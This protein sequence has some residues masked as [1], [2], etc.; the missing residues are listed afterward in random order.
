MEELNKTRKKIDELNEK[1]ALLLDERISLVKEIGNIKNK[2]KIPIIDK[3][4]EN[5][6]IEKL[7]KLNYKYAQFQDIEKVFEKIL[8]ISR[9]IQDCSY[10]ITFLGPR[11]TFSEQAAQTYFS[12]K[13]NYIPLKSISD[14]FRSVRVGE[15]D[16]GVVPIENSTTGSIGL[17]L[18][19]LL[20]SDIVVSGEIIEKITLCLVAPENLELKDINQIYSHPQP[21]SQ[22]RKYLEENLS[23]AELITTKSTANAAETVSKLKNAAAISSELAGKIYNLKIIRKGIE[24]APN[25]YTRFFVIGKFQVPETGK[26]KTSIAFS[27][28]HV[29]G[30]LVKALKVFAERNINLTKLESRPSK[31]TPW[32][33]FFYTDFEGHRDN[34]LCEEALQELKSYTNMIKIFGS[35][36][37]SE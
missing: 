33:Y 34:K 14:I 3:E 10:N 21:F 6:I 22:S 13:C 30:A 5:Q 12:P 27:V 9:I 20:E 24:D 1:I 15:A 2:N 25:N 37:I 32:E 8:S 26:D 17:T 29:P 35:Y 28:K 23:N 7:S 19:L 18:D 36:P 4:R 16:F 31:T 11:G